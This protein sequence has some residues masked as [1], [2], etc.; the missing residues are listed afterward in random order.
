MLA[1]DR[2]P[3]GTATYSLADNLLRVRL[4]GQADGELLEQ[5]ASAGF[6]STADQTQLTAPADPD[7]EFLLA[8]LCGGI[9][10]AETGLRS[11]WT[12]VA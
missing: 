6:M 10:D 5:L 1:A 2:S 9:D 11:M 3:I 8:E 12:P 7:R 4:H